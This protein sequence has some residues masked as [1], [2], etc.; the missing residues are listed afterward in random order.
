MFSRFDEMFAKHIFS[1]QKIENEMVTPNSENLS[2]EDFLI[3]NSRPSLIN[4]I[5]VLNNHKK[6]L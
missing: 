3:P 6:S 1:S 5:R 2:S 4:M